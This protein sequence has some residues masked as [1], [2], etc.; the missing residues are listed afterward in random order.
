MAPVCLSQSIPHWP[1]S[2]QWKRGNNKRIRL[3]QGDSRLGDAALVE[4]FVLETC[5][6][7]AY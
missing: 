6:S 4:V 1:Y 7:A 2:P 5:C 3:F